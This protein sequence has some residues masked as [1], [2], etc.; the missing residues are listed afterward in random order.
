MIDINAQAQAVSTLL[1]AQH[2]NIVTVLRQGWLRGPSC[3]FFD[4]ELCSA[5]LEEYIRG[6]RIEGCD[7]PDKNDPGVPTYERLRG[8]VSYAWNILGQLASG[9]EFMHSHRLV[10]RNL[11]PRNSIILIRLDF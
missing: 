6:N 1:T 2:K 11:Q 5:T 4:M 8:Q 10:H 9:T 3:Y 7:W